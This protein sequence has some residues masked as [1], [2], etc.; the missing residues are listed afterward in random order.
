[1]SIA[2]HVITVEINNQQSG[3]V[4]D[5]ERLKAAVRLVLEREQIQAAI[6]SLAV[7]DDA[8]IHELNRHYLQH[9]YPTDVLSFLLER[10][11]D[12]LEGE[13]IVSADTA[14]RAAAEIGWPA[15]NELLLYVIH[16]TLH[17]VGFD[18]HTDH[19]CQAMRERETATLRQ[20]EIVLPPTPLDTNSPPAES[21]P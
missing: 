20:L 14:I 16:G 6:V 8:T 21:R 11:E 4:V 1:M 10:E 12:D 15:D 17:L 18:D 5:A 7:V 3:L 19:D 13:V 2:T 9:D